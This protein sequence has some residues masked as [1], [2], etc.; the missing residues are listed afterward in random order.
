MKLLTAPFCQ[1]ISEE[2]KSF[3]LKT[4]K[5]P[6]WSE[7]ILVK[8][9]PNKEFLET[10]FGK[11]YIIAERLLF[12]ASRDGFRG[13]DFHRNCDD[14][15]STLALLKTTDGYYFGGFSTSDWDQ[16]CNYKSAP[17]SFIFSLNKK[18][19]HEIYQN[20]NKAIYNNR[21]YGPI[22]GDGFDFYLDKN[23]H[24]NRKSYSNFGGSYRSPFPYGSE[25]SK[26]YL[27][28]QYYFQLCDYEVFWISL[29]KNE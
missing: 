27:A 1:T 7:S 18:T 24:Q 19:K 3:P 22:F 20:Q 9:A 10:M 6:L 2:Q 14:K 26:S 23:C 11:Q 5:N 25:Q 28:G 21:E 12:R 15:G 8:E 13:E 4:I 17:G 29:S 16:S